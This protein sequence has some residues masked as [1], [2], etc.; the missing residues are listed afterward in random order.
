MHELPTKIKIYRKVG[1]LLN[2]ESRPVIEFESGG[3]VQ[4]APH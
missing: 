1:A 3:Y 4:V 2:L